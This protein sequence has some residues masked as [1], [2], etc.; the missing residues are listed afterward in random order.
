MREGEEGT[1]R[2]GEGERATT[3]KKGRQAPKSVV[4]STSR[5]NTNPSL[6][7]PCTHFLE[8][9]ASRYVNFPQS[10]EKY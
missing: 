9:V 4:M 5:G 7:V 10:R 1:G 8:N 3:T 6:C 2:G